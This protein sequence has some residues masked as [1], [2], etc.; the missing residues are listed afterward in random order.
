MASASAYPVQV[1]LESPLK[2]ARWRPLVHWLLAIP[3]FVVVYIVNSVL[4]L[5]AFI[6]WFAILFTGNIPKGL[7]DF[8]AMA[9]RYQWRVTSYLY[10]M[11][12]SYPP[13]EFDALNLD[14]GTDPAR[15]SVEYPERLSRGLIFIKILLVI[16]HLIALAFVGIAALFV[17][18]DGP[19]EHP[20]ERLLLPDDRRLPAV[21]PG[22]LAGPTGG[23]WPPRA[24]WWPAGAPWLPA[25]V[26]PCRS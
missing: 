2:V 3:Q 24:P 1:E 19:V 23:C 25:P 15:L 16:P 21:L 20:G 7:F 5:L 17:G 13:F 22:A 10:F 26:P 6:A 9:F 12:E 14:P 18:G 4:G 8:M 11:R